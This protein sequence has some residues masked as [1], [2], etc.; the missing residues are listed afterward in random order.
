MGD[1]TIYL[2][3]CLSFLWTNGDDESLVGWKMSL[4]DISEMRGCLNA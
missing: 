4:D 3:D 1:F 2:F